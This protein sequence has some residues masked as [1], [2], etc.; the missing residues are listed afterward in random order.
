MVEGRGNLSVE[1]GA[2]GMQGA[3]RVEQRT[4]MQWNRAQLPSAM[5]QFCRLAYCACQRSFFSTA[6][7][8][9]QPSPAT[10]SPSACPP[11]P[12]QT[13]VYDTPQ[14][15]GVALPFSIYTL[16]ILNSVLMG[17]VELFRNTELDPERRCY[18]GEY[19]G[20]GLRLLRSAYGLVGQP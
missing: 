13:V 1:V 5:H 8:L 11:F 19:G 4:E 3:V 14:Y 15:A 17:G 20:R 2:G 9:L 7:Q 12:L 10:P 6:G 16:A 18:P